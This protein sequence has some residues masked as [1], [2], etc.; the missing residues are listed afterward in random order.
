MEQNQ[1]LVGLEKDLKNAE[2]AKGKM[3][4]REALRLIGYAGAGT[5]LNAGAFGLGEWIQDNVIDTIKID[6]LNK[7]QEY[8]ETAHEIKEYLTGE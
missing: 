1:E 4:R 2:K 8:I 7:A 5:L 6:I 3:T